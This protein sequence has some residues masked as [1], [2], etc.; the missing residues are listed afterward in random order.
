MRY[1]F[2]RHAKIQQIS[3][4]FTDYEVKET[5]LI[6]VKIHQ[7]MSTVKAEKGY[8]SVVFKKPFKEKTVVI[9]VMERW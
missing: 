5:I 3:R 7:H 9:T 8:L 6:G 4:G 1:N 2:T